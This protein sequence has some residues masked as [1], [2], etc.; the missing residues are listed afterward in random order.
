MLVVKSIIH[1]IVT[2][3]FFQE[4]FHHQSQFKTKRVPNSISNYQTTSKDPR[5][6]FHQIKSQETS[7][8]HQSCQPGIPRTATTPRLPGPQACWRHMR[9][10]TEN[11]C[12]PRKGHI[13]KHQICPFWL[14]PK[15]K[16]ILHAPSFSP[17]EVSKTLLNQQGFSTFSTGLGPQEAAFPGPCPLSNHRTS[18]W[19]GADVGW[20]GKCQTA[21]WVPVCFIYVSRFR[22]QNFSSTT[23][24]PTFL[25]GSTVSNPRHS[26]I[27]TCRAMNATS[28]SASHLEM[29]LPF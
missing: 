16:L 2:F 14:H 29:L 15:I 9:A 10:G 1:H 8:L 24:Y 13:M 23:D 4:L 28:W 11:I 18:H 19:K 27:T 20:F 7:K 12:T 25:E 5:V 17:D 26:R 21:M 22:K 3:T 6:Y